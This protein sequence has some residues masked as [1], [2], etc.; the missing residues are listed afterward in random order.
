MSANRTAISCDPSHSLSATGAQ[1][2]PPHRSCRTAHQH[3]QELPYPWILL[4]SLNHGGQL[5]GLSRSGQGRRWFSLR[6][7]FLVLF[8]KRRLQSFEQRYI[9]DIDIGI[10]NKGTGLHIAG[11]I[12][13]YIIPAAGYAALSKLTVIPES[14]AKIG[15]SARISRM[16]LYICARCSGVAN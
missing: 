12:N 6:A 16:R 2:L 1:F 5:P 15:F 3:L 14:M 10:M 13:V 4:G 11:R 9:M 8:K 7:G